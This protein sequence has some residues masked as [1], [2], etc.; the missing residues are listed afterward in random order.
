[1]SSF[2]LSNKFYHKLDIAF[3]NLWW[4]FLKDKA[5]NLTLK[6]WVSLC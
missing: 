3:K 1:M 4:S 6:Y 5:K 2:L